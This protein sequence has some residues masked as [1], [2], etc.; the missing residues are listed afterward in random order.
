MS[1]APRPCPIC[2]STNGGEILFRQTF[3]DGPLGDGYNVCVCHRC[4]AGF[5]D[6]I[7]SQQELDTYYA[8]RSK[9]LV[10]DRVGQESAYDLRRFEIIADQLES[11]VTDKSA[12][13][14]DIGCATGG[15]LS[16]LRQ[17]GFKNVLGTDPSLACVEAAQQRHGVP[18]RALTLAQHQS[19]AE[20]FDVVLLVGVL[21]HLRDL[22]TGVTIASQLI[23]PSGLVYCAQPDMELLLK[24]K[25]APFQQ[26]SVEHVNFFSALTLRHAMARFRLVPQAEW[27]WMVEWRSNVWD[28][29]LSAGFRYG[30]SP[31]PL[32]PCLTTRTN[33]MEY[34]SRDR[35]VERIYVERIEEIT[36]SGEPVII[37]GTGTMTRRLLTVSRLAQANIVAF[38]D[39]N[40]HY[41]GTRLVGKQILSPSKL[42]NYPQ[43]ILVFSYAFAF[44]ILATIRELSLSNEVVLFAGNETVESAK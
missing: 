24:T 3:F 9:Y 34:I 17:R 8:E 20:R 15:L 41:E 18:A 6:G 13:F 40:S 31:K 36:T 37:W 4:G 2:E 5:A 19:W 44:E 43:K 23:R 39:S 14:L 30:D 11:L 7:P 12:R 27:H 25:N 33:L 38:A 29:V 28:S 35:D 26:F 21:E 32:G 16:V 22:A 1:G 42:A 10:G